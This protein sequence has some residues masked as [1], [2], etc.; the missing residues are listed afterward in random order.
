MSNASDAQE[1]IDLSLTVD[2][3]VSKMP[4]LPCPEFERLSEQ[5]EKSLQVTEFTM[6]TH[7]GTHVDAPAHA[8]ADGAGIDD[9]EVGRFVETAHVVGVDAEPLEAIAVDDVAPALNGLA[10]GDAVVI[11]AGWEDHVGT[12]RYHDHPYFTADLA[13]W[14][15]EHGVGLVGMDFLTPDRP[16][17]ERPDGFTYPVHTELLGNDVLI[18]ENLTNTAEL[19]GQ[20][21]TIAVAPIKLPGAD[22]AP[23]RAM[24]VDPT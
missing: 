8:I 1:W 5:G 20:S 14:F 23:V 3:T 2:P 18:L 17:G 15:V 10:P 6:A 4:V 7:I 22:G 12:E 19:V 13:E 24:A 21:T 9:L 11:R 16:P